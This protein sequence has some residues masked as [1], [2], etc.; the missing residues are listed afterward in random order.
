MRTVPRGA[1]K[2]PVRPRAQGVTGLD[3]PTVNPRLGVG[4]LEPQHSARSRFKRRFAGDD[5]IRQTPRQPS[6][7]GL[8]RRDHAQQLIDGSVPQQ[9]ILLRLCDLCLQDHHVPPNLTGVGRERQVAD[10]TN[11][12]LERL[13]RRLEIELLMSRP[14]A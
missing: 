7:S 8:D 10:V 1:H 5:E 14:G 12:L 3:R 6:L 11:H 4:R 2:Q 13:T 9:Q